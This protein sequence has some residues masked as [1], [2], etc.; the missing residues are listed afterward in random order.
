MAAEFQDAAAERRKQ[1]AAM[2]LRGDKVSVAQSGAI[3]PLEERTSSEAAITI[4]EGKLASLYW[5]ENDPEL[6]RD[7]VSAMGKFFP[8]FRPDLLSD[9]RM[10]WV[11][12]VASGIPGSE[13]IWLLQAVYDHDHP[14]G[15]GYG[16]SIK[17]APIDPTLEDL[18]EKI[19]AI[20]H[21][22]Q[23]PDGTLLI[24]TVEEESFRAETDGRRATH[25]DT[26]ASSIARAVKWIAAFELWMLGE[27]D[28]DEFDG[29]SI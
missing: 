10:S 29:H 19:G 5:Y 6:Y 28:T 20:P 26:A 25:C 17:V 4:P 27:I 1:L 21:T 13:R 23:L 8:Q 12:P 24:C 11:G 9:K 7:E 15:I 18:T 2:L 22:M 16:G 14:H 3:L